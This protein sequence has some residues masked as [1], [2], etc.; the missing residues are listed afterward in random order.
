MSLPVS[1]TRTCAGTVL[2]V[3]DYD[4]AR[5]AICEH[6]ESNGHKVL[7]ACNGKEALDMLVSSPT[8]DVALIVLDLQMP[9]MDGWKFLQILGTY[10]RLSAIPVLVVSGHASGLDR[11]VYGNVVGCLQPPY[12]LDRLLEMVNACISPPAPTK[13]A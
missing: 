9:V 13:S 11:S 8:P 4:E 6:L 5:A 2:V 12:E 7:C 1:F 3:D 10:V